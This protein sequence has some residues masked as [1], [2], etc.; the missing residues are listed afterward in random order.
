MTNTRKKELREM[1]NKVDV[2]ALSELLQELMDEEQERYDNLPECKQEGEY[3]ER[4]EGNI[5]AMQN[6]IDSLEEATGYVE[7]LNDQLN[8][9]L[10]N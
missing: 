9:G 1:L 3:G 10:W 2:T 4:L 5:D 6:L 8:L 7:E